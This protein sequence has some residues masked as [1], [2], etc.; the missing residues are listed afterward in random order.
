MA[1]TSLRNSDVLSFCQSFFEKI[2]I[3]IIINNNN[4]NN[5]NKL[6]ISMALSPNVIKSAL[7][8][9]DN[10]NPEKTKRKTFTFS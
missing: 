8:K 6:K 5:N 3:K 10:K 1:G 4:N 7:Q 9:I 2:L